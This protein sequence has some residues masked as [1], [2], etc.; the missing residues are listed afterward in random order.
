M[1]EPNQT[2]CVQSKA[3]EPEP[4]ESWVILELMGHQK[5]AGH[6][7]EVTIGGAPFLRVDVPDKDGKP[8]FSRMYSPGAV[9]AINPVSKQ[10]AIGAAARMAA[11]VAPVSVY[12]LVQLRGDKQIGDGDE[13]DEVGAG[14]D[15]RYGGG[16]C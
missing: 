15:N 2:A 16:D 11:S 6:L 10:I 3:F 12:D 9:Y 1:T 14:E 8:R 13:V 7:R 5:I 4:F